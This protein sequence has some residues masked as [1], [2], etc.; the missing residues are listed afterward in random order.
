MSLVTEMVVTVLYEAPLV[1]GT[2]G[3][4]WLVSSGKG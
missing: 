3:W 2:P 1:S 4:T